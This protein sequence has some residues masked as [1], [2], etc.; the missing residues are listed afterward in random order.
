MTFQTIDALLFTTVFLVPGF[1]W[2]A[3]HAKFVPRR[4]LDP[5]VRLVEYLTLSCVNHAV[6]IWM[7]APL[8]ATGWHRIHPGWAGLFLIFPTLFSPV[9]LGV[10][11]GRL[12]QSDWLQAKLGR[13]GFRTLHQ[14]PTSWD[15]QFSRGLPYWVIITLK[16]GSHVYG[17]FGGKSFAS[18]D[19]GE[20]DVY[21]EA[22]YGIADDGEWLPVDGGAGIL[23]KGEQISA[24][25]FRLLKEVN[26][27]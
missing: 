25:E 15:Y 2:S 22:V 23:I 14:I 4:A 7:L 13:W 18:D 19:P 26:Y 20:R 1:I 5:Q 24:V 21:L 16:D 3:L 27:G 12:Y 8:F 6:W 9:A 10:L 11:S 17:L